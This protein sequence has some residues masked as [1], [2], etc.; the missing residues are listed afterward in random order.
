MKS[1]NPSQGNR[2]YNA[3]KKINQESPVKKTLLDQI[4][5]VVVIFCCVLMIVESVKEERVDCFCKL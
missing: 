3:F 2:P 5:S 1:S 4:H